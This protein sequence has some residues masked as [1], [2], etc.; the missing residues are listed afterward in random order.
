MR[1][2]LDGGSQCRF[3][4]RS[5]IDNLQLD[6]IGQRDLLVTSFETYPT[7]H[8]WKRFFRFNVRGT[9]TNASTSLTAFES[10]HTSQHPAV[11]HDIK[12]LAHA[13]ILRLAEPPGD[14][15]NLRIEILI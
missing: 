1:S 13:C 5:V 11:P 10:T 7:A 6:V 4:A 9:W 3:K 14:P 12:T 15:E 8:G 2:V